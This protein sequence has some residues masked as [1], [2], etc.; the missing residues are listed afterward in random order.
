MA[1]GIDYGM[2]LSNINHETGIRYGVIPANDLGEA[3]YEAN[4]AD[5]GPATCE[6]CGGEAVEIGEV[7][8]DLDDCKALRKEPKH[9][10]S[11]VKIDILAIPKKHREACGGRVEWRDEGL[12][13]ACLRCARSFEG[14]DAFGE[15]PLAFNLDDG[16]Y[17][18]T[19]GGDD[20]DVFVIKS[21]YYTYGPFCSPCAPGAVYLRDGTS[22]P[23][24]VVGE[25]YGLEAMDGAPAYCFAPNW[26]PNWDKGEVTG[27]YD[28]EE[29]SCPYAVFRVSDNVCVFQPR[30]EPA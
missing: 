9:S 3:W 28:G 30:K 25:K 23:D 24:F 20:C 12:D 4:E 16:E 2:G 1:Q 19:Q 17:V 26:F 11:S 27:E 6:D 15:E 10:F 18:A 14:E 21:P 5:Y 29:T 8:F 22:S 13:Y 7:P